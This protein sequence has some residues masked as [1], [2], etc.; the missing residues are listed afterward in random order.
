MAMGLGRGKL[1]AAPVGAVAVVPLREYPARPVP[2]AAGLPPAVFR[3]TLQTGRATKDWHAVASLLRARAAPGKRQAAEGKAE[4]P[5]RTPEA[6]DA[7]KGD[8][9]LEVKL[10]A[11]T[12]AHLALVA[13]V[14]AAA[15][16]KTA[17][18][19]R[20]VERVGNRVTGGVTLVLDTE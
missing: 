7:A 3:E 9:R 20:V 18:V 8:A 16:P 13:E 4:R 5:P 19:Y 6:V 14:P 12:Q 17:Q 10:P 15:K 11:A 2:A 1:D